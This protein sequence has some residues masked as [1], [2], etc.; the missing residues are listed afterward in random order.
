MDAVAGKH[1]IQ[2]HHNGRPLLG[3][4]C[5]PTNARAAMGLKTIASARRHRGATVPDSHGV[6]GR[7]RWFGPVQ[8]SAVCR[9]GGSIRD[10]GVQ[11]RPNVGCLTSQHSCVC[12]T[13]SV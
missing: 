13:V 7:G 4:V 12:G 3:E 6:P 2:R 8:R 9:N 11:H 10:T 5:P 1:R